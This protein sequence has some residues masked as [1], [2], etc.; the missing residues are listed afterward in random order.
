MEFSPHIDVIEA[1]STIDSTDQDSQEFPEVNTFMNLFN[2][3]LLDF[4]CSF[5]LQLENSPYR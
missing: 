1:K 4:K 2:N 5:T 3:W